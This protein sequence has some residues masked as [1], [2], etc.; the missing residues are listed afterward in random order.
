MKNISNW[1][2]RFPYNE[3]I[4]LLDINRRF[5]L[6]ESTANDLTLGE[7]LSMAGGA[8]A[9]NDIK[10]GYGSSA[11]LPRL[12]NEIAS[13]TNVAPEE[14]IT[15]QGTA[16]GLFL[17]AFELCRPGDEVIIVRPCFPLAHDS[18]VGAGATIRECQL[19]FD[20]AYQLTPGLIEPLLNE[21]TKLVSLASPQ[22]PSGVCTSLADIR[23]ILELIRK[24]SPQAYLFIDETY[25]DAT[26][27]NETPPPSV[28]ATFDQKIITAASVS[29]AHGAP[30]L[31]VGWL[32]VP[33]Q[34]LRERLTIAKMN[35]VISGSTL[36]ETLAAIVLENKEKILS[37]RRALLAEG[38]SQV[39]IWVDANQKYIDWIKPS[40]G[41]LCCLRLKPD[42]FD[43]SGVARF[44]EALPKAELQIGNGAWFGESASILRL[45]F[46]YLPIHVLPLALD[47]LSTAL[48]LAAESQD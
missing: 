30:G 19:Q 9:L 5:N 46:G 42:V 35:I 11:G 43:A 27:G 13:L 22:N 26:Y 48:K 8:S 18:L 37:A 25:R 41:A 10:M 38:L 6:A 33:D 23:A 7:I 29:K 24:K 14:V 31:R 17:L 15:T 39:A 2:G 34:E 3:I 20:Q 28:A 36:D 4:S 32:T 1:Q 45:G 47:A 21:R 12:R 44:W 16:L 40:G